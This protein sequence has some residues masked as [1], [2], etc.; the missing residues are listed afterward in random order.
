VNLRFVL[1]TNVLVS[2]LLTPE[3]V[4]ARLILLIMDGAA[5][6]VVDARI[7]GEYERVLHRPKFGLAPGA[8]DGVLQFLEEAT[9]PQVSVPL[10]VILPDASDLPFLEVSAAADARLVTGNLRHFPESARKK[11]CTPDRPHGVSVVSPAEALQL[12]ARGSA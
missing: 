6:P 10:N 3:G 4:C 12:L 2:A 7:L 8:V 5:V 9:Q 11:T 1:D